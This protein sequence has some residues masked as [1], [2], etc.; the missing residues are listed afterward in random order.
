MLIDFWMLTQQWRISSLQL[1]CSPFS[2]SQLLPFLLFFLHSFFSS[3][4]CVCS[5]SPSSYMAS[6]LHGWHLSGIVPF[7]FRY[8][9]ELSLIYHIIWDRFLSLLL[10]FSLFL[11]PFFNT[12]HPSFFYF[13]ILFWTYNNLASASGMLA[14]QPYTTIPSSEVCF[15]HPLYSRIVLWVASPSLCYCI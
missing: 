9:N 6:C 11:S 3:S 2:S 12:P 5:D 7:S 13:F 14:L 10:I 4:S 15:S 8:L 1:I